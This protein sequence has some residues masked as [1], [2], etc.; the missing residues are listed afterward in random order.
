MKKIFGVMFR[1][2][3]DNAYR[4]YTH[5]NPWDEPN[6]HACPLIEDCAVSEFLNKFK[7]YDGEVKIFSVTINGNQ[8][9]SK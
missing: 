5:K 9:K 4:A 2:E 6:W 7:M 8:E 1:R 3:S